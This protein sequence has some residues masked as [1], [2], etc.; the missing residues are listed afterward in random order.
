MAIRV[1]EK[2]VATYSSWTDIIPYSLDDYVRPITSN[3]YCY[4]CTQAGTSGETEPVWIP[5]VGATVNDG[6][7][8]WTCEDYAVSP[9]PLTAELNV[10]GQGGYPSKDIWV[11][12]DY[13]G[14][15]EFV[16]YGSFN[17]IDWRRIDEM[18]VPHSSGRDNRHNGLRN[19]YPFIRVSTDVSAN[20][21]I[22]IVAGE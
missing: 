6:D 7:I 20:N 21:E 19:A 10:T 13:A 5:T 15:A 3:G 2:S 16:I 4:R 1:L 9:N 18:S 22:E 14:E 11:K 17:G 12:S 8:V